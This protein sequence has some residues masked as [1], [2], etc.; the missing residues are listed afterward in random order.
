[1]HKASISHIM[2]KARLNYYQAKNYLT[3][4]TKKGY[5]KEESS[6]YVL[7]DLGR[8]FIDRYEALKS[9]NKA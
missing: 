2:Q 1:M 6:I 9:I 3:N 7:L 4:L 8:E 5:I